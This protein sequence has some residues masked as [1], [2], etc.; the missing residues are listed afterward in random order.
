MATYVPPYKHDIFVSYAHVDNEPLAGADTRWVT[1][2]VT[3][4]RPM[5]G[6]KLGRADAYSLWMDYE[7]RGNEPVTPDILNQLRET[8]LFVLILSPGYL[9]SEW[10]YRELNLFI[11]QAGRGS[12]RVFIVEREAVERPEALRDLLGYKF[13]VWNEMHQQRILGVP[14]PGEEDY[15]Y[16]ERLGELAHQI[17]DKLKYLRAQSGAAAVAHA[18]RP[19]GTQSLPP[20]VTVFLAEVTDDLHHLRAEVE[21][22]LQQHHIRVL[23]DKLYYFPTA[24]ELHQAIEADLQASTLFVQLLSP[25]LPR[26]PPG[27]STP[28]LQYA[29]AQAVAGLPILQWRDRKV[30]LAA[31]ADPAQQAFLDAATVVATGIEEFKQYIVQQLE[32]IETR[33]RLEEEKRT[34]EAASRATRSASLTE[35]TLIFINTG[36][37]DESLALEIGEMLRGEGFE[38]SLPLLEDITPAEKRQDLEENLRDCDAVIVLYANTSVA[39]VREQLRYCRKMQGQRERPLKV[40]AVFSKAVPGKPPVGMSLRNMQVLEFSTLRDST[41]FPIFKQ[42]LQP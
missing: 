15:V 34:Q 27:M 13:W 18:L 38:F 12:G 22:Y 40:I 20:R 21:R 14:K 23:P 32:A 2:L 30:D 28:Q 42:A 3:G 35:D 26:R 17:A 9:A 33:K 11:G 5:L 24:E 16:Y 37:E 29:A 8:A 39:W 1:N 36:P 31:I 41:C 7:L 6:Q 10:C 19:S 25:T 4:L